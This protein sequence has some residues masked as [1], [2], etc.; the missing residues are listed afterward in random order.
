ML[1]VMGKF[2]RAELGKSDMCCA[3]ERMTVS[4]L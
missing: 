3:D 1:G 2:L 4:A